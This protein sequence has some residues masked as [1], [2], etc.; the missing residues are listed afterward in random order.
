MTISGI[1]VPTDASL[2]LVKVSIPYKNG[3]Q[4]TVQALLETTDPVCLRSGKNGILFCSTG[5]GPVNERATLLAS[6]FTSR[7]GDISGPCFIVE[8]DKDGNMTTLKNPLD[9]VIR[10]CRELGIKHPSGVSKPKSVQ[11]IKRPRTAEHFFK[12]Q[13][14]KDRREQLL[15]QQLPFNLMEEKQNAKQAWLALTPDAKSQ[16]MQ[17]ESEDKARY[18][19][20]KTAYELQHPP[21][22]KKANSAVYYFN[23]DHPRPKKA[24]K[25]KDGNDEKDEKDEKEEKESKRPEFSSLT[26][27]DKK[28]YQDLAEQDKT[29][30]EMEVSR[31][32]EYCAR[33]GKNFDDEMKPKKVA[34]KRKA[35]TVSKKPQEKASE[36]K[37][38]KQRGDGSKKPK[39][40]KEK[41]TKETKEKKGTKEIK[42]TKETKPKAKAK[43]SKR[44]REE[45]EEEEDGEDGEDGDTEVLDEE[46][47]DDE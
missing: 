9:E 6:K 7:P 23:K 37:A 46:G 40:T 22:P 16:Y 21:R 17:M 1:L 2:L 3:S 32:K 24:K 29:R 47:E 25:T 12:T 38:K 27:E 44:P 5:Q 30:Y 13:F 39:E 45:E 28:R 41:K 42:E 33:T 35:D 15:K 34:T 18:E 36:P 20:E 4:A 11:T 43:K 10:H 8:E 19:N 26:D 14:E 31:F